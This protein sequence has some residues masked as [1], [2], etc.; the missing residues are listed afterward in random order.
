MSGSSSETYFRATISFHWKSMT[1]PRSFLFARFGKLYI[2]ARRYGTSI[3]RSGQA[4]CHSP[5]GLGNTGYQQLHDLQEQ[6]AGTVPVDFYVISCH[7]AAACLI[8]WRVFPFSLLS[9]QPAC[10]SKAS[11]WGV[12]PIPPLSTQSSLHMHFPIREFCAISHFLPN[13]H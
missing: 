10:F 7:H 6:Q 3:L 13:V 11:G 9:P 4:P 5:A 2:P 1:V 12:F 8:Y